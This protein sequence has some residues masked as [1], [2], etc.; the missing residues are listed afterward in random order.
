M[1]R[2][3]FPKRDFRPYLCAL[4]FLL[5]ELSAMTCFA[6]VIYEFR[7]DG[8]PTVIGTIEI[9]SP[10]ATAS[11]GWS[12]G[13][14][15]DLIALFL[16]NAVSGFGSGNLLA[17]GGTLAFSGIASLDG[18]RLD[19]GGI[20][21]VFPTIVPPDPTSDPTIDQTLTIQ[22]EL[23]QGADFIGVST[24]ITFP[25]GEVEIGDLF[26]FG[27]WVAQGTVAIPEPGT[28][29]LLGL[30]LFGIGWIGYRQRAQSG[31]TIVGSSS[32]RR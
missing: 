12:T 29:T 13:D 25:G 1:R 15:S 10:P 18:P 21:I 16:D 19:G 6:G 30:G 14:E 11:S 4:S 22:F 2:L 27:D 32:R 28:L 9:Q 17:A 5:L 24:V 20:D 23:P 31:K 26:L 3:L 8:S 7:E